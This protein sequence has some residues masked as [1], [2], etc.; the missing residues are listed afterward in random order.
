MKLVGQ[1]C[2]GFGPA[3][4]AALMAARHAKATRAESTARWVETAPFGWPVVPEV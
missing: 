4:I 1:G 3:P 2:A